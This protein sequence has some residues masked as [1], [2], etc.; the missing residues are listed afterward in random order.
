MPRTSQSLH[1]QKVAG[2]LTKAQRH[3]TTRRVILPGGFLAS[4][5]RLSTEFDV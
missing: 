4:L 5:R 1:V 3:Q 2:R